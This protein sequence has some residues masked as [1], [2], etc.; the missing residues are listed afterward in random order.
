[1]SKLRVLLA[2]VLALAFG[3]SACQPPPGSNGAFSATATPILPT[4]APLVWPFSPPSGPVPDPPVQNF[5]VIEQGIVCRAAQPTDEQYRELADQGFQSVIS[6]RKERGDEREFILGMGFKYYLYLDIEDE[7]QPTDQ[8]AEE[9]LSFVTDRRHWPILMHCKVGVGRTG[10]MA[11][12]I[13]Y[14][15]DGWPLE[16][17]LEEA[18]AYRSGTDLVAPQM[19]WL[20]RWAATH[21]PGSHRP[22][23]AP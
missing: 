11:A 2:V 4:P 6:F 7:N 1:M 18:R 14:A 10:T 12:L 5:G 8:Q 3:S 20:R 19:Q 16:K 17:A 13:R 21:P 9:F 15:V 23:V 22:K